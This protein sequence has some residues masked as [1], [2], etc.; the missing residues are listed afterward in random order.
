[1]LPAPLAVNRQ[2]MSSA[3]SVAGA[4]SSEDA[5]Y[6]DNS[7]SN[8]RLVP[9]MQSDQH[10][11]YADYE[12]PP[13]GLGG[14]ATNGSPGS[15]SRYSSPVRSMESPQ[16]RANNFRSPTGLYGD[17]SNPFSTTSPDSSEHTFTAEPEEFTP[18]G[19]S[20]PA[21]A[22][23]RSN[24]A[25]GVRLTDGGPVPGPEGVRR[26][27]RPSGRRPQS[28]NR[29]SRSSTAFSLPPGAAPPQPNNFGPGPGFN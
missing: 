21:R 8:L 9:S 5:H 20:L 18:P 1:M 28:Q 7:D 26:V 25:S 29:Y 6:S 19:P 15:A 23:G 17:V 14:F 12:G 27:S 16:P 22:G 11:P 4:R 2:P 24:T 10:Q 3:S 13:T